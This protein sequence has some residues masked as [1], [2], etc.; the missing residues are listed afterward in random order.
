[1]GKTQMTPE[2][3]AAR[4][5]DLPDFQKTGIFELNT[6]VIGKFLGMRTVGT[7]KGMKKTA[8]VIDL[9]I[10]GEKL[11]FWTWTLLNICIDRSNP[12]I[13]ELLYIKKLEKKEI[14]GKNKKPSGKFGYG[15]IFHTETDLKKAK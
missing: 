5:K 12:K 15:L 7:P 8:S 11:S 9:E 3:F 1:M 4:I 13:G 2:Q 6:E 14:L 10:K